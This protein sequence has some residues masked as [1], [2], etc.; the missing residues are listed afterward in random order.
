MRFVDKGVELVDLL[1][2]GRELGRRAL[3]EELKLS[4]L[5]LELVHVICKKTTPRL[6]SSG[7]A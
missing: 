4:H 7:L 6:V 2:G 1:S 5:R 3:E